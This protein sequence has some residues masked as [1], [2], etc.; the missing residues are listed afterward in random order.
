MARA[1]RVERGVRI[2]E[3]VAAAIKLARRAGYH[4]VTQR[5]V[6]AQVRVSR[7]LIT[8]YFPFIRDLHKAILA[9]AIRDEILDIVMQGIA[10]KDPLARNI[11]DDLR[12]KLRDHLIP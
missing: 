5:D 3:I 8:Y 2:E 6:A 10:T 12:A 11:S 7:T 9:T 1:K 4:K